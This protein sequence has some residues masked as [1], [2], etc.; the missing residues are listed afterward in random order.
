MSYLSGG[1]AAS[2]Y[3]L[4]KVNDPGVMPGNSVQQLVVLGTLGTGGIITKPFGNANSIDVFV[5]PTVTTTL[6]VSHSFDN[7]NFIHDATQDIAI[8][9]GTSKIV[10]IK[11]A[12]YIKFAPSVAQTAGFFL[13]AA[14]K[15]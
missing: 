6:V 5:V 11:S 2:R 4:T 9:A 14:A 7:I 1:D 3:F 13:I 8:T 12:P 15:Y 10:S